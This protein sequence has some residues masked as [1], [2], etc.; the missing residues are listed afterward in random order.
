MERLTKRDGLVVHSVFEG[1][2]ASQNI[3]HA[4]AYYEDAEEQGLL[5]RLPCPIGSTVYIIGSKYRRGYDETWINTGKFRYSDL[6]KLGKTVFLTKEE[7][8]QALKEGV[9]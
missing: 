5:L 2:F 9:E 3:S 7:A 6:E 4:L 1:D 8:E